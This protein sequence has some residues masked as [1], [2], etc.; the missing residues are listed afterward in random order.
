MHECTSRYDLLLQVHFD[1][2]M[3]PVYESMFLRSYVDSIHTLYEVYFMPFHTLQTVIYPGKIR[4]TTM[5]C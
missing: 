1:L 2:R 3:N 4:Y 5:R